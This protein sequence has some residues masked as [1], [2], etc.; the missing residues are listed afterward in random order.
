MNVDKAVPEPAVFHRLM[1]HSFW[2]LAARITVIENTDLD[3]AVR[4]PL[5]LHF[6]AS[7]AAVMSKLP[8]SERSCNWEV[9]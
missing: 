4:L 2:G 1:P 6:T 5:A 7:G 9:Q 8:V 3:L